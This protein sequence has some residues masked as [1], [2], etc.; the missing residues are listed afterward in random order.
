MEGV[1]GVTANETSVAAVTV[2]VVLP[3]TP[4]SDAVITELPSVT[5]LA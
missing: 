2:S 3:I 1:A 4:S 5:P